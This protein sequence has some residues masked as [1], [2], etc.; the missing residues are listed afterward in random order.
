MSGAI[1]SS[2]PL[3][4]L[5]ARSRVVWLAGPNLAQLSRNGQGGYELMPSH[6]L[7]QPGALYPTGRFE[8]RRFRPNIVVA[9]GAG[10]AGFIEDAW[11]GRVV[12]IGS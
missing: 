8:V 10:A 6:P 1:C 7:Q 3:S 4:A 11:I 9:A 2:R 5:G 12:C